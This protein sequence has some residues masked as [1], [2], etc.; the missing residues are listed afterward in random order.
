MLMMVA[1]ENKYPLGVLGLDTG[2]KVGKGVVHVGDEVIYA[3]NDGSKFSGI[4]IQ[5]INFITVT[6]A[7]GILLSR[8][9]LGGVIRSY[10]DIITND[11]SK[12]G[13]ITYIKVMV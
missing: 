12:D 2:V 1:T 13:S 10:K 4:V 6:G 5:D 9:N 3:T 11:V 8:L 7:N